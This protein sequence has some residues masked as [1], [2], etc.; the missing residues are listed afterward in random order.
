MIAEPLCS[1]ATGVRKVTWNSTAGREIVEA[2][3]LLLVLEET[4]FVSTTRLLM[5]KILI[6]AIRECMTVMT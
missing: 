2:A 5:N 4:S 6:Y 1:N 3:D